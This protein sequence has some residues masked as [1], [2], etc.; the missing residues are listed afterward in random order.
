[1]KR[2]RAVKSAGSA[3]TNRYACVSRSSCVSSVGFF[4]GLT[5]YADTSPLHF[6]QTFAT[7]LLTV[8]LAPHKY[9]CDT[10]RYPKA[11]DKENYALLITELR[12]AINEEA[13]TT[14][15]AAILLSLAVPAGESKIDAG[16]DV[17]PLAAAADWFGVMAYDLHGSW[18]RTTGAH[19]ALYGTSSTDTLS[20]SYAMKAWQTRGVPLNKLV[21]GMATY[22]RGW[23]L[24]SATSHGL[25]AMAKGGSTAGPYTREMGFLAYVDPS[26]PRSVSP[27]QPNVCKHGHGSV[28]V[29]AA[30][31][32]C[33]HSFLET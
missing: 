16:F 33:A 20:A 29:K 19:S 23:T 2:T 9:V 24:Y 14:G 32:C 8:T 28:C 22:G 21:M 4:L 12:E 27:T 17:P 25:G 11:Q 31:Y 13:R 10:P 7:L 30:I 6:R 5:R 15:R 26:A 18:E 1:M 3:H